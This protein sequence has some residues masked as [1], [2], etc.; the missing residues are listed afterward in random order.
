MPAG[1]TLPINPSLLIWAREESG[2]GIERLARRLQVKEERIAAWETGQRQPT[3]RQVEQLAAFLHRPLSVF[4]LP[5]PPQLPP[6]AA[7]YRRLPG[8]E[9]G[10][11]SPELRLALRH[12]LIRRDNA[13]N[14]MGELGEPV[15]DFQLR[16]R[17]NESPIEVGQ[18]MREATRIDPMAQLD[19]PNEWRAWASWRAAIE[20]I[21]ILVFQFPKVPLKETRGLALLRMPLPVIAIN[22]KEMPEA[23]AYTIFHEL[24]HLMLAASYEELPAISE[25]RSALEWEKVERF[26]EVAASHALVPETTLRT[27]IG[28]QGLGNSQWDI[29][30][31]RKLARAFRVTPLAMATRLRESGFMAWARYNQ[32]RSDWELYVATLRPRRG[33]FAS[34]VEKTVGRAGRPFA[35]LVLEALS[36]N[37]LTAVDASRY[38]DL[39]FEHFENLRSHLKGGPAEAVTDE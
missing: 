17:L 32:W 18:R 36:A 12:M 14:L 39:R 38:L 10:S 34:P 8:V 1:Q 31:V 19:W 13:L 9:P 27:I 37:R 3:L 23:K 22:G 33:G 6:L 29:D 20:Q 35:Q 16:A 4:F 28:R 21:G 2:Y 11:E 5:R 30:D 7:D 25:R 26:A 24:A 15:P